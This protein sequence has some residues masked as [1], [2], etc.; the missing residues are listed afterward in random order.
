MSI[1]VPS[2][3][4]ITTAKTE[5]AGAFESNNTSS[6][7]PT[8]YLY[9]QGLG[10][11]INATNN[12]MGGSAGNL[13]IIQNNN[14][15]PAL[16]ASTQGTG[17]AG[18]VAISNVNNQ[19]D[20]LYVLTNGSGNTLNITNNGTTESS[21]NMANMAIFQANGNTVARI[22]KTG[23]GY[24]NGGTVNGGADVAEVFDF[25]GNKGDFETGDVLIVSKNKNRA[26]IKSNSRYSNLVIGVYATKPGVI[27]TPSG[28]EDITDKKIPLG[29]IGVIPTKV[30]NENGKIQ[31]GDL[32]VTSSKSGY[33]MKANK[34]KLK[35]GQVIGKALENFGGIQGKIEVLVNIQ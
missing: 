28:L 1:N 13:Q 32:L 5:I 7:Y 22:D 10:D 12:G 9:N 23:K 6:L 17:M 3:L 16:V 20:A 34:R 14:Y 31:R 29:I 27:L 26:V 19:S 35:I 21:S 4:K 2:S 18:I 8:L 25:E 24:F 11:V 15:F 33:A 30:C